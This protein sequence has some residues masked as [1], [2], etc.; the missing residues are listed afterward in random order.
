MTVEQSVA[1]PIEQQMSGVDN[2][3]Y[4]YSTNA[5]NG[6]IVL[7]VNFD[8]KTDPNT[9]QILAQMR[10]NQAN[11]QLP[12]D[13]VNYGVTV[14]KSTV[15]PLMLIDLYSPRG[16]YDNIFL[17][18]YAYIN[19]NDQLTRVP[20]I[21][22]VTVFGAGQY[23]MRCWVRPDQ[24]AKLSVTVPGIVRAIQ[25]QNTV[26]SAGQ[27]G[28]E[29]VPKGQD[30][31]YAVRAQGRLPTAKEFGEMIVRANSDG[32][33]L[34]LKDVARMELGAQTYN[35]VGRY[36]GKPAAVVAVYQLPGSNAVK[37]AAGV[38][39]LMQE[40]QERF[41]RDLEYAVA[42]DTTLAVTEGLK[43]IQKTLFEAIVL[44]IIVVYIFLQGWRTTVIPLLAVPV[45]LVGTFMVFPMLGFSIN[46]LSLFG[47][48][49]A[50]GIVVD[51]AIVVVEAV[52]HHIEHG[53]SPKDAAYKAMEGVSGPVVAIALI[54]AA[55]FVP[56]AFIPGITG[57]MYQQFSITIAISVI[58]SAFNALSLS[59]ALAAL[60]LRPKKESRGPLGAFSR[61][62]NRWFGRAT[63]GYVSLCGTLIRKAAFS[64]LLLL[65]VA[66]FAGWFGSLLPH[67][68]LPDED[69][70]YVFAGLQLPDA[71]SLQR[72]DEASRKIEDILLKTPGVHSVTAVV[73]S[74][75]LSSV[76]N[77]YSSFFWITLKARAERKAPDEQYEAIKK[78]LNRELAGIVFVP[79][80]RHPWGWNG[81]RV[82]ILVGR[83]TIAGGVSATNQRFAKTQNKLGQI[84][85]QKLH[86]FP[87]P[88]T[89]A[90]ETSPI[91]VNLSLIWQLDF[92]GQFRRATEAARANLLATEWGRRAVISSLVSNVTSAYFQ[93]LELDLEKTISEQTLDSRKESLN[94]VNIRF[95]GGTTGLLDVR[96]SEQLVYTAAAAIPDLERRIEQQENFISI[97]LG[98]NPEPIGRGKPLVE[99]AILPS[100]PAG[101]P[102]SLSERRPDIQSAEQ[103][104]I[105]ANARIG[106]AK[107]AYFPEI[108]LTGLA[109]FQSPALTNLFTGPA[110]L[111][112]FGRQLTQPIFTAGKIRS[113]VRFSEAQ[114]EEFLPSYQQSIQEAFHEVSD[115][116]IAYRKNQEFRAQQALV[117]AAA[118]GSTR[119]ANVRYQGG[120]SSYREV[121]DTDT[122][123]FNAQILL[124]QAQLKSGC[125]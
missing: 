16:T 40:A 49:L 68:F 104:L 116:L 118:Q 85:C 76:Q 112:S 37:A 62:F 17:A 41:P 3:N 78:H 120:V 13:V 57:R 8:I 15:A 58:F 81:R 34:R 22:S 111:W 123:S 80:T 67:S 119:L 114:K 63:D 125:H 1:T 73:G 43:E 4:M 94:L 27:I 29:P 30:F 79:S 51:D 42:L 2:M 107:A 31:T 71:D 56:T 45:S 93:L 74:S 5:N 55:V 121:L 115:S 70:G 50:I 108:S 98:Q 9:D 66:I 53:L 89:P 54:L 86:V 113:N 61:W 18:N 97:L 47:L 102:S 24:L 101:L 84:L 91:P 36:S 109:G 38:R 6:Q 95:K 69:Q 75:M 110:G 10:T 87:G 35:M 124:A 20:G 33:V 23:A 26:N 52:E 64:M 83:P 65:G 46:T 103:Q 72:T 60:M 14:Q 100:V 77:T 105:A 88:I 90:F 117:A 19:L 82:H 44:V 25:T 12:S 106:V 7:T 39:K 32:S 28:G 92:W 48:V 99:I 59:P 122:L 21:A 11:S 96:Q